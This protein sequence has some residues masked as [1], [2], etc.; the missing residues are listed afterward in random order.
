MAGT[1]P[2]MRLSEYLETYHR[3]P[4]AKA[5][6]A[7]GHPAGPETVGLLLRLRVRSRRLSRI[8]KEVDRLGEDDGASLEPEQPMNYDRD[9]LSEDIAYLAEFSQAAIT[10]EIGMSER[11]WRDIVQGKTTPRDS[12]A[13]RIQAIAMDYY[14]SNGAE[15]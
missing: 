10:R 7:D 12:R 4:E 1:V 13:E 8:G 11:R 3:H 2:V 15:C 5:A 9:D 6:D 14:Q